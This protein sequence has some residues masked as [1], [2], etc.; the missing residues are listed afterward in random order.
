[1]AGISFGVYL[2]VR[3]HHDDDVRSLFQRDP[4]ALFLISAVSCIFL[5]PEGNGLLQR[6]RHLVGAVAAGVI[7]HDHQIHERLTDRLLPG[8]PQGLFR[9]IR[10]HDDRDFLSVDHLRLLSG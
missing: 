2:V 5:L 8:L 1:M 3:M 10:G 9:I 6:L 4:V 7:H